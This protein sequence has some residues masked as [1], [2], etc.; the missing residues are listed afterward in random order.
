M[1]QPFAA[2]QLREKRS[3]VKS[4]RVHCAAEKREEFFVKKTVDKRPSGWYNNPCRQ[5]QSQASGGLAQ[6]GERLHGMQEVTGS[7]PV[8]STR[9]KKHCTGMCSAFLLC[10]LPAVLLALPLGELDLRSKD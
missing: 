7:I 9:K 1:Q 2:Q 4:S 10:P 8:I 5:A 3:C 6:L